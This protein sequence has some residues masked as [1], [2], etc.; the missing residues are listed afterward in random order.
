[1]IHVTVHGIRNASDADKI[2]AWF[3]LNRPMT[4]ERLSPT[5]LVVSVPWQEGCGLAEGT[6]F[7]EIHYNRRFK[8][9]AYFRLVPRLMNHNTKQDDIKTPW[10]LTGISLTP[11]GDYINLT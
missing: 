3:A 2:C 11:V 10:K 6:Q 1:M 5:Q 7:I 9:E 4:F 8:D